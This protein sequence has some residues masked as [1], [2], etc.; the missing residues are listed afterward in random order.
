MFVRPIVSALSQAVPSGSAYRPTM[1]IQPPDNFRGRG[2]GFGPGG[3]FG[4]HGGTSVL[5][6]VIFALQL[7]ML[8]A[9]ALLIVRSFTGRRPR[10]VGGPPPGEGRGRRFVRHGPPDPMTQVRMRYANG[11]ISREE[12]LQVTRDLGG[13]PEPDSPTEELPPD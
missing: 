1:N 3:D 12:Y 8:A 9:L 13:T 10:F 2:F 4:P 7:L 6:W 5:A 11:D